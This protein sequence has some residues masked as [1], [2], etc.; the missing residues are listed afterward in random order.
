LFPVQARDDRRSAREPVDR[1]PQLDGRALPRCFHAFEGGREPRGR[2]D[3]RRVR[4]LALRC[5][6]AGAD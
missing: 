2:S 1:S 5:W 4:R 3:E 6:L